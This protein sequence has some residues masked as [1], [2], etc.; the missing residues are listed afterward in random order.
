MFPK[1]TPSLLICA[2]L[3]GAGL[4]IGAAVAKVAYP[5]ADVLL[6]TSE[7][8]I[9]QP[10]TYPAG[11]ALVTASIVT[12]EPGQATGWHRHDAPLVG[13]LLQGELTV[14]YGPDGTRVY[15]AGDALVE[16]LGS[17]HNGTNTGA[18]TVRILAVSIGAEGVAN[19]VPLPN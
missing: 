11:P 19:T 10:I 12:M 14:D 4:V 15:R 7:T 13:Y 3:V 16:A 5:T 6:A 8:V 17:A 9:G 1:G 18:D 2:G